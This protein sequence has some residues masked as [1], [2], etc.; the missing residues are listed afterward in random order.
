MQPI[1][2]DNLVAWASLCQSVSL[3]HRL[4]TRQLA[5]RCGRY[6]ITVA[7]YSCLTLFPRH[8]SL[9]FFPTFFFLSRSGFIL[10]QREGLRLVARIGTRCP[11][12]RLSRQ[13]YLY[14][15]RVCESRVPLV[16]QWQFAV[17]DLE[18]LSE[19]NKHHSVLLWRFCVFCRVDSLVIDDLGNAAVLCCI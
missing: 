3:S 13:G 6:Y 11:Y 4:L 2:I 12:A 17:T 7:I 1:A 18:H 8:R 9:S 19:S 15:Q 14:L 10:I 16:S 5:P